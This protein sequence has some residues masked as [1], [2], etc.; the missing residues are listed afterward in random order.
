M[1]AVF[2]ALVKSASGI[3]QN[4]TFLVGPTVHPPLIDVLLRFCQY[5]VALAADVSKMYQAVQ[6]T[7]AD[8][9]LHRFVWRAHPDEMLRDYRMSSDLWSLCLFFCCEHGS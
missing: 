6:L 3:S 2:D 7:G 9:D 1:R 4:E 5:R 8:R